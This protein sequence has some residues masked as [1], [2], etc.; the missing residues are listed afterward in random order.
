MNYADNI[1]INTNPF[2]W[3]CPSCGA[4]DYSPRGGFTTLVYYE[5]RYVNGVNVNPDKNRTTHINHCNN[6]GKDTE[7]IS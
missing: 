2:A 1:Q 5:P 7:I 3:E 4:S 6:C